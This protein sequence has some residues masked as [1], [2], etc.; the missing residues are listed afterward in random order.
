MRF[1]RE[2]HGRNGLFAMLGFIALLHIVGWGALV[3]VVAPQHLSVGT[4]AFGIGLGFTA[5]MLGIRHAFD[6]DH[7][8]AIDNT[9]RKLMQEGRRPVS[10][11]FWFSFGHSSVVFV[12]TLLLAF[13]IRA[14]VGPLLDNSSQLHNIAGLVGTVVSSG[15]L[16]AIAALNIVVLSDVWKAFRQMRSGNCDAAA[17]DR[18]FDRRG[19]MSRLLGRVMKIVTKPWEMY[20]VGLLFGLGFDTATE[21]A[22]LVL[23][24]SGAASGLPW[25]AVLCLPVLFAAGMSLVD[26]LDGAFM[27]VAYGWALARPAR[28]MY[29][30]LVI[31]GLSVA[32]ALMIGTVEVLGSLAGN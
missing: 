4:T 17:L 5:Y 10:V 11:G 26:T 31:T 24:S 7:I 2:P 15:F 6:A 27:T 21:I 29:Y 9:T 14:V 12:L 20:A 25:Y 13:G 3:A 30:N 1:H 28:K 32:V 22:L 19:M 8:A 16:Y 18:H 23:T